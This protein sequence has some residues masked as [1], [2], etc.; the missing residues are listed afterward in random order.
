MPNSLRAQH[1]AAT[2]G[3]GVRVVLVGPIED[4]KILKDGEGWSRGIAFITFSTKAALKKMCEYNEK[5]YGG[6]WLVVR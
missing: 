4:V 3:L 5:E 1:A 6:R 2:F